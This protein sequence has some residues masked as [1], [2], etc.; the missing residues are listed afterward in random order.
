MKI[1]QFDKNDIVAENIDTMIES[2]NCPIKGDTI[3]TKKSQMDGKVEKTVGDQVFFRIAD[4][5]LMKTSIGNVD[6][7]EKLADE[8][9]TVMEEPL[10]EVSQELLAR[11]KTAAGADA[12]AADKKG[13]YTR[14]NKRFSGIVKATKKQ[15][16]KPK[17]KDVS[18]GGMGGINRAAPANDVSY[19]KVL[20][21]V[22]EKWETLV[23]EAG[24]DDI[25]TKQHA[26]AN[27]PKTIEKDYNGW[28]IRYQSAPKN[29]GGPIIWMAWHGKKGPESAHR[30][31]S[32]TPEKAYADAIDW[33][34]NGAGVE[35]RITKDTTIDFN[36]EFSRDYAPDGLPFYATISDGHL[37]LADEPQAGFKKSHP[38]AEGHAKFQCI[39]I[40]AK[41]A[42]D[43]KLKPNGRYLLGN[44]EE[45]QPGVYMFPLQFQGTSIHSG[46]RL[47]MGAPGLTVASQRDVEEAITPWGGYTK[48]DPKAN[49]LQKAPKSSM[50]GTVD[51]PF[52]QLVQDTIKEHGI[53]W[54]F[55]YYVVKHGLPP[56][57]FRIYAG[58]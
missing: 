35:T 44:G 16:S 22:M 46:D 2:N 50:Q 36:A 23:A 6:V 52:S 3:R 15:F 55:Q 37:L 11:Y 54:A 5:R 41:D 10:D 24:F 48:D 45:I 53:K 4:G 31:E 1:N 19:E 40:S 32:Q 57:H 56:R 13:D 43:S 49:A 33:I 8:E 25:L 30:G 38:R 12:S 42:N 34:D 21:E 26:E 17:E 47:R 14:G 28:R 29:K 18:E 51:V 9:T 27:K 20:D 39:R 58:I 7:V